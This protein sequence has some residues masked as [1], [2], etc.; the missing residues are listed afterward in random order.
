M[1][2]HAIVPLE[3]E[4]IRFTSRASFIVCGSAT[5]RQSECRL[6]RMQYADEDEE[7]GIGNGGRHNEETA[8]NAM[9]NLVDRKVVAGQCAGLELCNIFKYSKS[10]VTMASN[11]NVI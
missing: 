7:D 10:F 6:F 8:A 4:T 11:L 5:T 9:I 3:I 2:S 1:S